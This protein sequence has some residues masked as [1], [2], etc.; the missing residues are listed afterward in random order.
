MLHKASRPALPQQETGKPKS[1][2]PKKQVIFNILT[3]VMKTGEPAAT[4]VII[5][6]AR[7]V[8]IPE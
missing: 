5:L 7:P 6:L 2:S 1:S 3:N 8:N 4:S